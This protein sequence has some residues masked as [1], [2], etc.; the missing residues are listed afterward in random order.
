VVV[1]EAPELITSVTFL[2]SVAS[3][4]IASAVG[5]MPMPSTSTLSLTI[6]SWMSRCAVSAAPPSSRMMSSILRP[7]TVSPCCAM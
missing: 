7:A 2:A 3:G 1:I 4:A 6:I 5:V